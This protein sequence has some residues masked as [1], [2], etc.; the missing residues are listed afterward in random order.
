VVSCLRSSARLYLAPF[1]LAL[2]P[3]APA[4]AGELTAA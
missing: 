3:L 1:P 4:A 2:R